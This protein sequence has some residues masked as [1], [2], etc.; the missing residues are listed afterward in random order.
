MII[1]SGTLQ[2]TQLFLEQLKL[3]LTDGKHAG[4]VIK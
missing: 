3:N 2:P 4:H 1:T